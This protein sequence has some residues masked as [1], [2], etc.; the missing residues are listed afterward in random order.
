MAQ[1]HVVDETDAL[2]H[3]AIE[4]QLT[5]LGAEPLTGPMHQHVIGRGVNT[6]IDLTNVT[7]IASA[8]IGLLLECRKQLQRNDAQ[9]VLLGLQP[10]VE[11][12][13][14]TARLDKV[15]PIV[16][17]LDDALAALG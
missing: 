16:H 3:I 5:M 7:F 8:G 13:F 6:I 10:G 4:G 15:F 1:L 9:V 17:S 12:T 11:A 14:Q 2:T